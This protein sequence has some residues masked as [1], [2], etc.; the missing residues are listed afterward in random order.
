MSKNAIK[1]L[2][3]QY[4]G[5]TY[6]SRTEARWAVFFTEN[7]IPFVYEAD[8]F[9]LDGIRYLPD[10]LLQIGNCWF[11]VKPFDPLPAEIEKA[12]R[13]ARATGKLVFIAPGGPKAGIELHV[14]SP[15]GKVKTGWQ[16]AW[17][18]EEGVGYICENLWNAELEVKIAD[19]KNPSGMY[20]GI[21]PDDELEAAGKH[22]FHWRGSHEQRDTSEFISESSY[23]RTNSDGISR[24]GSRRIN[25]RGRAG[26]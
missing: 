25:F 5:I 2:P 1:S 6:R 13:L 8:G 22:Q 17:A 15:S 20:G 14:A 19:V 12:R 26:N 10:F 23:V 11:E 16:F 7:K 3:T 9:D 4:S 24:L 18:H 21:G